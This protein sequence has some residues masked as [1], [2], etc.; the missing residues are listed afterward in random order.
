VGSSFTYMGTKK[1]IARHV[2]GV[3]EGAQQGPLLDLFAGVSSV[4][5]AVAPRRHVWCNDIQHFAHAVATSIFVSRRGPQFTEATLREVAFLSAMNKKKIEPKLSRL[6]REED[7]ALAEAD[8]GGSTRL[9]TK[10]VTACAS[11]PNF[12]TRR[13]HRQTSTPRPYRLFAT[14]YAGGYVGI[15]QA[16]EIDSLRYAIDHLYREEVIDAEQHRWSLLALCKSVTKVSNTTGH[17]AQYLSIKER[18]FRRFLAK[19]RRNVFSEWASALAEMSPEGSA[20]WRLGNRTFRREAIDLLSDLPRSRAR[21]SVIYA[22][23][24]Y[25][26]D[27]YSRYYHLLDTL[28]LYDYPDPIGKGQYRPD[29]FASDFSTRTKV[30]AA[31]HQLISGAAKLGCDLIVNYPENGLLDEPRASLLRIMKQYFGRAEVALRI[32]HEHSSL[33]ASKGS[34][35]S[36]VTELVFYAH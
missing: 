36:P 8:Y 2:A 27:H 12:R 5:S 16:I 32:A 26:R 4:G 1:R 7:I 35:R 21:P 22:D 9:L 24:P 18:T 17:F 13:L 10:L 15:R 31:F 29:R 25:T 14:T 30:Y 23:P 33:G 11:E 34:E 20:G 19:R 6:I 28:M 3:I